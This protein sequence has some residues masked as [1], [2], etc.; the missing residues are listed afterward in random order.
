MRPLDE[1]ILT[2]G[3]HVEVVLGLTDGARVPAL[4]WTAAAAVHLTAIRPAEADLLDEWC[5]AAR[6]ALPSG[7]AV[8]DHHHPHSECRRCGERV[9]WRHSGRSRIDATRT[10]TGWACTACGEPLPLV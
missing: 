8:Y 2:R 1:R 7:V 6:A 4:P 5:V 9:V 10:V 3:S